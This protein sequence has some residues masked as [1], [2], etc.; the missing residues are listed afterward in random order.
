M[1]VCVT[2]KSGLFPPA[3]GDE[4]RKRTKRGWATPKEEAQSTTQF[5]K[6]PIPQFRPIVIEGALRPES[7]CVFP[8]M[9]SVRKEGRRQFC[10]GPSRTRTTEKKRGEGGWGRGGSAT[11]LDGVGVLLRLVLTAEGGVDRDAP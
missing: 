3:R 2:D 11:F 6:S 10:H 9:T 1:I 8:L 4:T 7:R 5:L